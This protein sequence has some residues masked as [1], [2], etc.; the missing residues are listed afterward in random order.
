MTFCFLLKKTLLLV[1]D[2][3]YRMTIYFLF[4]VCGPSVLITKEFT[5]IRFCIRKETYKWPPKRQIKENSHC[6]DTSMIND[7]TRRNN[8]IKANLS[9]SKNIVNKFM[10]ALESSPSP[11][12]SRFLGD[13][14]KRRGHRKY[15]LKRLS[16]QIELNVARLTRKHAYPQKHNNT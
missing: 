3:I 11:D 2:E 7:T 13:R 8:H 14:N 6:E 12:L 9:H 16:S 5:L 1:R 4:C 10:L 15:A